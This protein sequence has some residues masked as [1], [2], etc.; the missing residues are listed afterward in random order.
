MTFLC[1]EETHPTPIPK[2]LAW[3]VCW[4][5]KL[6]FEA[7]TKENGDRLAQKLNKCLE[8]GNMPKDPEWYKRGHSMEYA[9]LEITTSD[10]AA[11]MAELEGDHEVGAGFETID[12]TDFASLELHVLGFMGGCNHLTQRIVAGKIQ[13]DDC[14]CTDL[15]WFRELCSAPI[16]QGS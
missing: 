2:H 5:G 12:M 9:S 7:D 14:G 3:W 16:V 6:L 10:F 15:T 8:G 11:R 13:C 4:D 1:R